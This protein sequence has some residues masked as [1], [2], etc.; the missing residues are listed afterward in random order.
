[1]TGIIPS[2]AA[3][4]YAAIE[5]G[6]LAMIHDLANVAVGQLVAEDFRRAAVFEQRGIDFCC[7][8]RRPLA[9]AC[10]S[11]GVDLDDVIQ[12]LDRLPSAPAE[13]SDAGR[14]SPAELI[15]HIELV[16]HAYVRSASP[17][18]AHHLAK[19]ADAHGGRHPEIVRVAAIFDQLVAELEQHMLKEERILFPY[20]RDLAE[21]AEGCGTI[22]SPFG[23][24]ENPIR[25]ME[26]EHEDAADALTLI[27]ELTGGYAVPADGCATYEVTMAELREFERDLHRHVHLENNVLFPAAVRIEQE[28]L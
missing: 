21:P 23:T 11:A 9:D 17:R 6:P 25:M 8:G 12:A 14:W 3:V 7:N 22:R 16:H 24:V 26:R 1:M 10:R 19:L 28:I 18:I 5:K 4:S 15:D 27:R 2:A 13:V 20:V